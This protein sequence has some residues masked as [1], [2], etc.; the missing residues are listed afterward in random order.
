MRRRSASLYAPGAP[1]Q[2]SESF[3]AGMLES[4]HLD[5]ARQG[6]GLAEAGEPVGQWLHRVHP[7]ASW[8]LPGGATWLGSQRVEPHDVLHIYR[9]RRPGQLRDVS[10]LAPVLL[11]LR[12]LGVAGT[13]MPRRGPIMLRGGRASHGIGTRCRW[14]AGTR[15]GQCRRAVSETH[16]SRTR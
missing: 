3:G 15:D 2:S 5:T 1:Q 11:R 6:V 8:V 14:R 10:W 13:T 9:N 12:D 4:D 7:G 16:V